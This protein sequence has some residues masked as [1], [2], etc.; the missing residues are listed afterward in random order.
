MTNSTEYVITSIERNREERYTLMTVRELLLNTQDYHLV[1]LRDNQMT[2]THIITK[3][4][5]DVVAYY[6]TCYFDQEVVD[7]TMGERKKT[8]AIKIDKFLN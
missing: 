1:L 3:R 2:R 7:Y 6:D 4:I 8:L 5:D